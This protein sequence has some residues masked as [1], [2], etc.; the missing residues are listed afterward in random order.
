MGLLS[1]DLDHLRSTRRQ[2][3]GVIAQHLREADDGGERGADLVADRREK[4][5]LGM[6]QLFEALG[7]PSPLPERAD[8]GG[9]GL[10]YCHVIL[11]PL[12]VAHV[13]DESDRADPRT[14]NEDRDVEF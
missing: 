11:F 4:A 10:E 12:P 5:V 8:H 6:N 3:H 14:V 2:P 1:D 9:S 13:I 7:C